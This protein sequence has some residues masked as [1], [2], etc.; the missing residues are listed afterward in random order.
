MTPI[1]DPRADRYGGFDGVPTGIPGS[2]PD[3]KE[4]AET[5]LVAKDGKT[6]LIQR[7]PRPFGFR[8]DRLP[9]EARP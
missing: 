1:P 8:P 7:V 3:R 5:L 9:K 4:D 2:M 6:P